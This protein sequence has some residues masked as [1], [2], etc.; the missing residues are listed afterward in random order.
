MIPDLPLCNKSEVDTYRY[1]CNR[2]FSSGECKPPLL[3][4]WLIPPYAPQSKALRVPW[5]ASLVGGWDWS[6]NLGGLRCRAVTGRPSSLPLV[7][8]WGMAGCCGHLG[9]LVH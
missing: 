8:A 4:L 6:S 5:T 9:L 2:I 7:V 3:E 1:D